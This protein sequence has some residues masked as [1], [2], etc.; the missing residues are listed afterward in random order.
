[1]KKKAITLIF[2][3]ILLASAQLA[4][5]FTD[6]ISG[7][8]GDSSPISPKN[9]Q[10]QG[11]AP[12]EESQE[13]IPGEFESN[14]PE[15]DQSSCTK[16]FSGSI[17]LSEGQEFQA[18]E[19]VQVVFMLIN[20]G[21]CTWDSGYSLIQV[22]GDFS[23]SDT[24]LELTGDVIPGD[25][26]QLSVEYT[27]PSQPG[28]YLSAWKMK[29]TDGGVFG[30]NDPPNSPVRVIIRSIPSGNP[31][32]T[33]NPTQGPQPT[34]APQATPDPDVSMRKNGE[35]MLDGEC[36]DFNHGHVIDCSDTKADFRYEYHIAMGGRLFKANDT[37]FG[38]GQETEPDKNDCINANYAPIPQ[39]IY[40]GKYKPFKIETLASTTYGW[41]YIDHFDGNG[42]TFDYLMYDPEPPSVT[43]VPLVS[44]ESQGDQVS[45]T[46]GQCF[47]V[48]NGQTKALCLGT[49]NG[50]L[51]EEVT[52]K[53][54]QFAQISH[55][56]IQFASAMG[57]EPS[58]SDCTGASYNTSPIWPIQDKQYY[59]YKFGSA[60]TI[61]GWL[62]PTSYNLNG[63]TF[64]YLTWESFP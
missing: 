60:P 17:N 23:P 38:E 9:S 2:I 50:F 40:E 46:E 48:W 36:Y 3:I 8:I 10:P 43:A 47:D 55:H 25:S 33:P 63:L 19:T 44:V 22:G 4:C 5:S 52:K 24:S 18:G 21:T 39:T 59:C 11:E 57:S 49:F 34:Q 31:Q 42:L 27:A 61:Y 62:R 29:D 7:V 14:L 54:A 16:A 12:E 58:K 64:D 45:I 6:V 51:F 37:E 41:I 35:T 13:G 28:P 20:T 30:Q 15:A 53:N 1:M 56:D 32:P 26:V